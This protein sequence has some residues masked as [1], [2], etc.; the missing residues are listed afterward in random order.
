MIEVVAALPE[1]IPEIAARMRAQ[2]VAEVMASS[3]KSPAGALEFSLEKS[4]HAWTA[5][6]DGRPKVMFG[7]SDLNVLAGV[8]APW[9][10][11]TDAVLDHRRYFL[12]SSVRWRGQLF[13]RYDVL[14]NFV[15][16]RNT[17]AKRWLRWMGFRFSDPMPVGI[18]GEMFRMFEMRR[19]D[20][21][22][23]HHADDRVERHRRDRADTAGERAG[24]GVS[25]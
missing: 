4:S 17:V 1:H 14:R 11:G 3:G 7:V 22:N 10:L 2:D 12:R 19:A 25:V 5:L 18:N 15:D 16:D 8:A 21:R 23:K 9:L 20:V 6:V 24:G 13:E